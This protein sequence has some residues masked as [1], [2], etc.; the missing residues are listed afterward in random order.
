[1]LITN[2]ELYFSDTV[3]LVFQ[4]CLKIIL[5]VFQYIKGLN[6]FIYSKDKFVNSI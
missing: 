6:I 5:I 2:K 4:L 1:M 3:V